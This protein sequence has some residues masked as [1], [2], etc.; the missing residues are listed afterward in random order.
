MA[1]RM[2]RRP[3]AR[4]RAPRWMAAVLAAALAGTAPAGAMPGAAEGAALAPVLTALEAEDWARALTLAARV[5]DPAAMTLV[6]WRQLSRGEGGFAD[7][8]AFLAAHPDWPARNTLR[9]RAEQAMTLTLPPAQVI[10][11]FATEPPLSGAGALRLAEALRA[12]GRQAE[13]NAEARRAWTTL[14]LQGLEESALFAGFGQALADAHWA[15]LD[16]LLWRGLSAEAER[17][18]PRV[19]PGR[20]ALA[21][22]R[23]A[24]RANEDGVNALIDRVPAN[25]RGDPGL[26]HERFQWRARRGMTDGAIEM[27]RQASPDALGRADLWADRRRGMARTAAREGRAQ[28]AYE[29][30]SAHGLTPDVGYAYADLEWISGWVALRQLRDPAAA[31]RHFAR[32]IAAVGTPISLGRGH[33]WLGR[34]REARG[35]AAG[36]RAAYAEGAR[37]QTS[38]YGQLAAEKIGAA[39]DPALAGG[40][41]PRD[42]Q[43][44][45]ALASALVRA[46][47]MAHWAGDRTLSNQLL[48]QAARQAPNHRAA[49][50]LG[51]LAL[52]L[53]RPEVAVRIAK[54]AAQ[55]GIVVEGHYY[56]VTGLA[57]AAGPVRPAVAMAIARQESEL[58]PQAVSPAGA[59]GLMQVMPATAEM[60]ARRMGLAYNQRALTDDWAYNARLGTH[61]LQGLLDEFGS[62]PLAAAGY[63]AGR[64]R[65][66][67]W[68]GRFGDPRGRPLDEVIDWMEHIP[69]NETRNYVQRV[70][71]GVA[72]YEARIA[73]HAVPLGTEARMR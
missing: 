1:K 55:N 22:A 49:G 8:A 11:F 56:P 27:I 7:Y 3:A 51:Q 68:I 25:L 31:E 70:V 4:E 10:G 71:E 64:G 29:L 9:R 15:R 54:A 45:P 13:A 2:R 52:E 42:W 44:D 36:A 5:G 67:E 47:V 66:R 6:T 28:L 60:Q 72:V 19:D 58:D 50:A 40:P 30:A 35:D 37:H 33:Y 16:M 53:D 17:M 63:N 21:R 23:I 18:I 69:F 20:A 38:F 46:G 73:G 59:R 39:P 62:L 34:A 65:V 61:Y 48:V 57:R 26:A 12:S 24:L 32:F 43:G 14:S 41:P